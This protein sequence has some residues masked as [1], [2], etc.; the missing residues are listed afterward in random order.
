[1]KNTL[2]FF[3]SFFPIFDIYGQKIQFYIKKK[4][5]FKSNFGA[6][7]SLT[8]ISLIIYVLVSK[9]ISLISLQNI[10]IISSSDSLNTREMKK[11]NQTIFEITPFSYYF[12]F[13]IFADF[14]NGT[15]WN[16]A[17]MERFITQK[18]LYTDKHEIQSIIEWKPC[19]LAEKD[20]FLLLDAE[21][22]QNDINK[23]LH[24]GICS[25]SSLEMGL[26]YDYESD[27]VILP[28]ITYH[29]DKCKNTTENNNFCASDSE[30][31]DFLKYVYLDAVLPKTIFDFN[32]IEKPRKR[33]FDNSFYYL[34][35]NLFKAYTT[36]IYPIYLKTDRGLIFTDYQLDSVDFNTVRIDTD[37]NLRHSDSDTFFEF[38][39][40][41]GFN[42][43][44]YL[45][46]NQKIFD[47]LEGLGGFINLLMIG[48]QIF[49]VTYNSIYLRHKLINYSFRNIAE[50]NKIYNK[51][52]NQRKNCLLLIIY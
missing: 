41:F 4:R 15:F 40:N 44:T 33:A 17:Q 51:K 7:I 25:K 52:Y 46:K 18:I 8:I 39:I 27:S 9:L 32:D 20:E 45:R 16:Y 36:E 3:L 6:L 29:I 34:D 37:L 13:S 50:D 38:N 28:E 22:I 5:M 49:C 11:L 24:Y 19:S 1:M 21:I 42:K 12:Y 31:K 47:I 30:I 14:L 2:K 43:Q 48:G 23:T 10:S 35:F 26:V